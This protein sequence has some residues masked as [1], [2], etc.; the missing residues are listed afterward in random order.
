MRR[1]YAFL[2]FFLLLYS[3][4]GAQSPTIEPLLPPDTMKTTDHGDKLSLM[5]KVYVQSFRFMGNTIFSSTELGGIAAPYEKREIN[6]E[7]LERLREELSLYYINKGYLNSGV[8]ISDQKLE[9]GIITLAVI[10]GSLNKIEIEGLKHFRDGY[11]SRRLERA[12]KPPVNIGR[13]QEALQLLQQDAR[14]KRINAEFKPGAALGEGVLKV[15][16]EETSP[17]LVSLNFSNDAAPSTGSYRGMLNL[18]HQNLFGAGDILSAGLGL[19]EGTKDYNASYLIPLHPSDTSL[20]LFFRIGDSMVTESLFKDLDIQSKSDTYGL[21]VRQPVYKTFSQEL[22][23]SLAGE[24]RQSKTYLL[25]R[26]FSFSPGA[27][28]GESKESVLRF[29]QEWLDRTPSTVFAV[30]STFSLGITAL[31]ATEHDSE[32]DGKFFSWLG[33]V[34]LI[35]RLGESA[36]QFVFKTDMQ[37][38]NDSLLS[39][40]KFSVGGMNSVRGYRKY[41]LVTDNGLSSSAEIRMPVLSNEKGIATLQLVPFA[42]F[43]WA[44]NNKTEPSDSRTIY[45]VGL[46][47]KW[48]PLKN[49]NLDVFYGYGLKEI[50]DK[51][52]DLQDKGVHFQLTW[53]VM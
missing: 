28:D 2:V 41:L 23:L 33:Q 15:A 17:Y 30:H 14:I 53:Q 42:D 7:E 22:A 52:N 48:Q 36:S 29:S 24:V 8:L 44:W 51:G 37:W 1:F 31:G 46:G 20:E 35:K 26:P 27:V 13:L 40:E 21:R 45:S 5:S 18:A 11:I 32:A 16:I 43:G 38:A 49:V 50:K 3:P 10:E 25:D 47:L 19:T 34:L 39:L 9:N 12:A 4:A 6:I